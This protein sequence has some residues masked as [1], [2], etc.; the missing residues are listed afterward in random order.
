[1]ENGMARPRRPN[2]VEVVENECLSRKFPRLSPN[3][4]RIFTEPRLPV[5]VLRR[6]PRN[7]TGASG[8]RGPGLRGPSER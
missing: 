1:M 3:Y 2:A 8:Y 4:H 5:R 6:F 7:F